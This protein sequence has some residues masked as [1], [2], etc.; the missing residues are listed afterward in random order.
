[1][2]LNGLLISWA[3]PAAKVPIDARL[4]LLTKE[5]TRPNGIGFA[6]DEK[7]LY[8]AQSDPERAVYRRFGLEKVYLLLERTASV[9]V[10][11]LAIT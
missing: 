9:V 5:M 6:P 1:M 3:I 8:V 4:T 10:P 7:T 2:A 11:F